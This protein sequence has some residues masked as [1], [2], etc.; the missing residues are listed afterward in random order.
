MNTANTTIDLK[1]IP[2]T[3]TKD[4]GIEYITIKLEDLDSFGIE[5]AKALDD[6]T[7]QVKGQ[8]RTLLAY[9]NGVLY[10]DPINWEGVI[11]RQ[12]HFGYS[13]KNLKTG[14]RIIY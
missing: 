2:Y 3:I 1:R 6:H 11:G 14:L 13:N 9:D 7:Y 12:Y 10:K 8:M 5:Q 4:N